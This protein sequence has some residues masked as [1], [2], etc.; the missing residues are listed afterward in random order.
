MAILAVPSDQAQQVADKLID[1]NIIGILNFTSCRIEVPKNV[2]VVS[3]DIACDMAR[4][5]Y[6][7]K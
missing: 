2:K 6:Y 3:I 1:N 4:L 7:M 5:P